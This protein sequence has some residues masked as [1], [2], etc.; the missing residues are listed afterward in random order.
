MFFYYFGQYNTYHTIH[1]TD[2]S[3]KGWSNSKCWPMAVVVKALSLVL[4][5]FSRHSAIPRWA[6]YEKRHARIFPYLET[7]NSQKCIG[8]IVPWQILVKVLD[9]KLFGLKNFLLLSCLFPSNW[10]LFSGARVSLSMLLFLMS[11]INC[12]LK[13]SLLEWLFQ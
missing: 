1:S 11:R 13:G 7:Q 4:L 10:S 9:I 12:F 5:R 6:L 2:T 3:L 8:F